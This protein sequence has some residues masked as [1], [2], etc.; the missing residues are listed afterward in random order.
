MDLLA[1]LIKLIFVQSP[2]YPHWLD[3]RNLYRANEVLYAAMKGDVLETGCG[4]AE[5]KREVLERYP[6]K[7]KSYLA[8]DYSSWDKIFSVQT[9]KMSRFGFL[10]H[11]LYGKKKEAERVDKVCNA[12]KLP[13]PDASFDTY[14]SFETLEHI[15]YPER[16]FAEASR[17]LRPGGKML[18]S[19][20]FIYREHSEGT[21]FDYH[22][23]TVSCL[24]KLSKDH[25]LKVTR[26][27]TYS[28]FGTAMAAFVNQ[29]VVRKIAEGHL[30]VKVILFILA[31]FIFILTNTIGFL[32]DTVDHDERFASHYHLIAVK[33]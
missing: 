14:A 24:K 30:F 10:T 18:V 13:F 26:I 6:Q 29:Y 1:R 31:P 32:I 9:K 28:Y 20:P 33:R 3:F 11:I 5:V 19:V 4:N 16:F 7:I 15:D 8:T 22:R 12:L 17:V 27:F 25:G 21:G 2:I 23:F